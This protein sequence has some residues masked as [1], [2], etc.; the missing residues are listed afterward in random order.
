MFIRKNVS[1]KGNKAYENYLLVESVRTPKGPRQ[2]TVC[3]LGNLRPRPRSEWLK[4]AHKVERALS[5][6][7]EIFEEKLDEEVEAIVKKVR[8]REAEGVLKKDSDVVE[9]HTDRVQTEKPREV[10]SIHVGLQIYRRLGIEEILNDIGFSDKARLLTAAMVMNRLVAPTSE[11]NMPNW[12]QRTAMGDLLGQDVL[13]INDDQLYRNLD[14]L[15][16]ERQKIESKLAE[17]E[18]SL[19]QL[20][21]TVYLY[22]LTSTYFEGQMLRNPQ[23]KR[24]YSRDKRPDCKQVVVGL[25]LSREGFP[26]CHEV[27]DGNRQDRTTVEEMLDILDGR[28]KLKEG[29][30]VVVDRGMA[31]DENIEQIKKR[32]LNYLVACRQSERYEMLAEFEER[33]GWKEIYRETSPTNPFQK[34]SRILIKPAETEGE[35]Y[36]LCL[37]EGRQEK[38]K[39]IREKQEGLLIEDLKKLQKRIDHG[40]IKNPAKINQSIGRLKERYP[41]VA[42]YY[43]MELNEAQK[44]LQ[45]SEDTEKKALAEELDGGYVLKTNRKDLD[46]EEIWRTYMLLT[47]VES[48]FRDM[49]SPLWERPIFH[50]LQHRTQTHIFLCLLAYHLLVSIEHMLRGCG[51][52]RSWE[53]VREVLKT[54]QVVTVVLPTSSGEVLRIRKGSTPEIEHQDI[55]KKLRVPEEPMKPIKTWHSDGK[56]RSD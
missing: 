39:N 20:D 55:Y 29:E 33:E 41:R 38:D 36:V 52:H 40:K 5:E 37:S 6:Q 23:A 4:L 28:I 11:H 54:H 50:Q 8:Q 44:R 12:V 32:N 22:D 1:K 16:P 10:G 48:A 34:K 26:L 47:R 3:S 43:T 9:I 53:T 31:Y 2:K 30:T 14:R 25:V 46:V 13:K 19:F 56:R 49:K 27:F 18:R 51:D 17:K 15:H 45:W 21:S 35:T 7:I 24:G 42:K